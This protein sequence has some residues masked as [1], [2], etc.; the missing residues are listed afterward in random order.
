VVKKILNDSSGGK[1]DNTVQPGGKSF[2]A[3]Q[4]VYE[5]SFYTTESYK[6][7][8]VQQHQFN[9]NLSQVQQQQH[10]FT[11]DNAK[12]DVVKNEAEEDEEEEDQ[13]LQSYTNVSDPK[14]RNATSTKK[15][16][17]VKRSDSNG[18]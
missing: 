13:M 5:P 18:S 15:P 17:K 6:H 2:D 12:L 3:A 14:K 10:Y 7:G 4:M 16:L 8:G 11:K 9:P 1:E